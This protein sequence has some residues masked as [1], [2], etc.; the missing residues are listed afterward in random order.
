LIVEISSRVLI[1]SGEELYRVYNRDVLLRRDL[2]LAPTP[3]SPVVRSTIIIGS[4]ISAI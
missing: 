4:G 1:A 2:T 3:I